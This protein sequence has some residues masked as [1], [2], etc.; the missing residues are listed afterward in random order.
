MPDNA[1]FSINSG[2]VTIRGLYIAGGPSGKDLYG[3]VGLYLESVWNCSLSNN[4]LLLT[5]QGIV[6]NNSQ[7]NYLNGNLVSLGSEGIT[8]DNSEENVLS[9]N[10]VVKNNKGIS[11][12]NS[13][14]NTLVNNTAGS[15]EIGILLQMSQGNK[16]AYNLILKNEYGIRGQATKSNILTN[17]NLYLNGIGVYLRSSSN[18]SFYKNE[19][20]NFLNAVD[21]GKN[22]WNS[23]STGNFWDN[24]TRTDTD[25]NGIIE[26]Q[27]VINQTAGAIDYM[28]LLNKISSDNSSEA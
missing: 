28:P 22:L 26:N 8:L 23:S 6:L 16:L 11:L 10:Q 9:N 14:N 2:N 20:I 5:D 21:E 19:F 7:G 3:K 4:T 25:G 13:A 24:H 18:N 27:Y 12:K 17:N 15:N 1:V